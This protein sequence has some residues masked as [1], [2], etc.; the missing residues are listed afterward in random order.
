MDANPAACDHLG[1]SLDDLK[2]AHKTDLN[3]GVDPE[4]I[5]TIVGQLERSGQWQGVVPFGAEKLGAICAQVKQAK[6][7]G[8]GGDCMSPPWRSMSWLTPTLQSLPCAMS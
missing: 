3:F 4:I 5:Q 2:M 1:V 6:A 7:S 8:G